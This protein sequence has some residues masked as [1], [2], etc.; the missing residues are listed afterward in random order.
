MRKETRYLALLG[1]FYV[2]AS[3]SMQKKRTTVHSCYNLKSGLYKFIEGKLQNELY[4]L[5]TTSSTFLN[6]VWED[7]LPYLSI[8]AKP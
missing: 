7:T 2:A 4:L 5:L 3:F 6:E 8:Y 1:R